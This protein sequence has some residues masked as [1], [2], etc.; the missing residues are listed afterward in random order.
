MRA[1]VQ[2]V[3]EARVT[4]DGVVQGAI[5]Y[6]LM[7]LLGIEQGDTG[8]DRRYIVEKLLHL[9]IF[10]DDDGKFNRSLR[11]A[12]GA[13]LLVSQFTLHGDCR[14]G[15][16]PSFIAAAHPEV[17]CDT[18]GIELGHSGARVLQEVSRILNGRNWNV[19]RSQLAVAMQAAASV[20]S[21]AGF[22]HAAP[23]PGM[24]GGASQ[25][26]AGAGAWLVLAPE[27]ASWER[28]R[29]AARLLGAVVPGLAA[30]SPLAGG[31]LGGRS[32]RVEAG[33]ASGVDDELLVPGLLAADR[34]AGTL[35]L[36]FAD[37]QEAVVADAALAAA[38]AEALR[39]LVQG[40]FQAPGR[41]ADLDAP[42]L[43]ATL[44]A[45]AAEGD[46]ARIT[47][48]RLLE[49]LGYTRRPAAYARELWEHL[50]EV[51]VA[52]TPAWSRWRG[53]LELYLDWGCLAGRLQGALGVA[54]QG[55]PEAVR[56]V[57]VYR[58]LAA[59]GAAGEAFRGEE[60]VP[61]R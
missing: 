6:G 58:G 27:G 8:V 50:I 60:D 10:N 36:G 59:R 4:V 44:A 57:A 28:V 45:C 26:V 30:S 51:G 11:D 41:W 21:L 48:R 54:P 15:R 3:R 55:R 42:R 18:I 13:V 22:E 17:S 39:L 47:D 16:R 20:G 38:Q 46:E 31:R 12:G 9:R 56:R 14:R 35:A 25:K 33:L 34:E 23:S 49:T 40:A 43:A 53:P 24:P 2:R 32:R 29:D 19:D 1:V 37:A 5:G 7:V 61:R 52:S